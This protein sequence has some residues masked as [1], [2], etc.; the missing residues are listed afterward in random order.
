[1]MD[2]SSNLKFTTKELSILNRGRNAGGSGS[3]KK[4]KGP[5]RFFS[6]NGNATGGATIYQDSTAIEALIG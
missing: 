2:P 4:N 3:R 6:E 1:M 5:K